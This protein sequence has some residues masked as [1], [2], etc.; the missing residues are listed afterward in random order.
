MA[1]AATERL[2]QSLEDVLRLR[3]RLAG[4]AQAQ[5]EHV[6]RILDHAL[7]A[8]HTTIEETFSDFSI[9]SGNES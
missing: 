6:T 7:V 3:K 4:A 8:A 9:P 1:A 5:N 2:R